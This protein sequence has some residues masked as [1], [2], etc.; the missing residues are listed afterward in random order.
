[1]QAKVPSND[2]PIA[3][4]KPRFITFMAS[5]KVFHYVKLAR[6]AVLRLSVFASK[7]LEHAE[8]SSGACAEVCKDFLPISC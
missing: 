6:F 2:R 8:D 4:S 5:F 3:Q 7:V 1:M